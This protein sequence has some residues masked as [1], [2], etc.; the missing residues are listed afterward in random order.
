MRY[1]VELNSMNSAAFCIEAK[2]EA[3]FEK[4]EAKFVYNTKCVQN[5]EIFVLFELLHYQEFEQIIMSQ[6]EEPSLEHLKV[7]N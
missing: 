5:I 2:K 6:F 3:K 1:K 4:I 7:M